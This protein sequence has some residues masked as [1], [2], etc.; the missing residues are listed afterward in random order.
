MY[1]SEW[2]NIEGGKKGEPQKPCTARWKKR[3]C[4]KISR[5]CFDGWRTRKESNARK[6]RERK[7]TLRERGIFG[8]LRLK[9]RRGG[10]TKA[11]RKGQKRKGGIKMAAG[12]HTG[13]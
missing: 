9:G 1:G 7:K 11:V 3:R 12:G 10:F 2:E 13:S 5:S 6:K 8:K 4:L